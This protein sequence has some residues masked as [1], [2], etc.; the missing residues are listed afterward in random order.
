MNKLHMRLCVQ[1]GQLGKYSF[2]EK[3]WYCVMARKRDCMKSTVIP[4][5][6]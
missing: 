2:A 1:W 3:D 5:V 4:F 6:K